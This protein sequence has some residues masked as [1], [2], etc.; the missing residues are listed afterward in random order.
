MKMKQLTLSKANYTAQCIW[1][2]C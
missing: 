1:E 2:W